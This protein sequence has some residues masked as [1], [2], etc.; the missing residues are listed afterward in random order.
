MKLIFLLV[1]FFGTFAANAQLT[2]ETVTVDYDS[3]ITYKNLKIIP[4]KRQPG[5]GSPAKPMMTLNKALSQG[6][7]TITERGTASTENVHWLRINNHSDV[8]LFVA[9]G[10]IV[11]GGR[12]D[13]MVTRDT[14]LNPTGGD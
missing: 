5:K 2:Y 4:I 3:A 10:E 12:Q 6:L 7:V 14:V 13:R 9:S 8:P 1:T 11:L